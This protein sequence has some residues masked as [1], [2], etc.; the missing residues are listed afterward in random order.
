MKKKVAT[1]SAPKDNRVKNLKAKIKEIQAKLN[2]A[3]RTVLQQLDYQKEL[4]DEN[5]ILS[6][7]NK[8]LE[9]IEE[10]HNYQMEIAENEIKRLNEIIFYLETKCMKGFE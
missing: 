8:A 10:H 5:F 2:I 4:I 9:K 1:K 3:N 6:A 7:A